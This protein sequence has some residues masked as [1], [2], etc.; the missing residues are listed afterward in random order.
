MSLFSLAGRVA[1]VTGS[2]RGLGLGMA[3]GLAEA[4]ATVVLNGR[5]P[6]TLAPV[7]ADLRAAGHRVDTEAFDVSDEAAVRAGVEAVA[8]RHGRLDILLANAGT[9]GAKPLAEWRVEDW[10]R[11]LRTN[12]TACFFAAQQA[13]AHMIRQRHG[14]IIFTGSLTGSRGRPTIHGYAA[15]KSAL[16]AIARTLA[17][18]LGPHGITVNTLAPGY[19][20]TELSAGLRADTAFVERMTT[21]IPLRRW[22]TPRDLAGIAVFLASEAGSYVTG[23]ELYVDGGLGTAL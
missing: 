6:A 8:A 3:Q 4:G 16:A 10:D 2:S 23:Q 5:D 17:A 12:L 9:H 7:A 18:E 11:V 13:A 1:L 20:E 15:S 21:R 14:R 22:G 19:F